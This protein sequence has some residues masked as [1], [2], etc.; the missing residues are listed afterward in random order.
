MN[1]KENETTTEKV[2][3]ELTKPLVDR[4]EPLMQKLAISPS[5]TLSSMNISLGDFLGRE[6]TIAAYNIG[7]STTGVVGTFPVSPSFLNS[8]VTDLNREFLEKFASCQYDVKFTFQISS[9]LQQIGALILIQDSA[10][11]TIG[12][13]Q[14]TKYMQHDPYTTAG[15]L[16]QYYPFYWPHQIMTM[17]HSGTYEVIIPWKYIFLS[18]AYANVL[19]PVS[20]DK[21]DLVSTTLILRVLEPMRVATGVDPNM[22]VRVRASIVNLRHGAITA[23]S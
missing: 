4:T 19:S 5:L 14:F 16:S 10:N 2:Y 8:L 1:Q 7:P 9:I 15:P 22:S 20:N 12:T 21:F 11:C 3:S 17:G 6:Q 13:S 18:A 23:S